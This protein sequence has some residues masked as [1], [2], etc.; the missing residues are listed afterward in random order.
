LRDVVEHN[1]SVIMALPQQQLKDIQ[2]FIHAPFA[3]EQ[4]KM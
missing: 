3:L 4:T 2:Q 1:F